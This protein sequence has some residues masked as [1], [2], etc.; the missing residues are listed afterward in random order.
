MYKTHKD[1]FVFRQTMVGS[2]FEFHHYL[3]LEPPEVPFHEHPFYEV[4]FFLSGNAAYSVEGRAYQLCPGDILLTDTRDI[5]RPIVQPGKPYE[6]YVLW[7]TE[8]FLHSLRGHGE[9]LG[10]CFHSASERHHH[11]I[12]PD[13]PTL[14]QLKSQCELMAALKDED[15]FG[16]GS[17]LYANL[18]TFLVYLNRAY[19]STPLSVRKDIEENETINQVLDYINTHLAEP[20]CL[21]KLSAEF[22]LSKFYLN[23]KFKHY[24]GLTL[25][26]YVI[27]KRLT[28]ARNL[29]R[30]G[31]PVMETCLACG[32]SD[33]SNFLK[34]FKR[35]FCCTPRDC[36]PGA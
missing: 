33:Y 19:L 11:L 2:T 24:T 22:F 10:T 6:R 21:D 4:Y 30:D 25:Y 35:E 31:T 28:V 27:K 23:N 13:A 18:I 3:D 34:A 16:S 17:L 7:L 20:L 5:H 36:T 8:D 15:S 29:L 12:R 1:P 32:F 26:Q 9:D 14:A